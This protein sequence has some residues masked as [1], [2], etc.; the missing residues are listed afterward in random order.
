MLHSFCIH[1]HFY[2]PDREDPFSNDIPLDTYVHQLSRRKYSNWNELINSQCYAPNA[3]LG[4]F[5]LI[6]FDV[7]R[8][9]AEWLKTHDTVT[10]HEIL[11]S[12][13]MVY[14]RDKVS[15]VFASSWDHVILPLM[16]DVDLKIQI[17]WGIRDFKRRFG[18]ESSSFWLPETAVSYRVL[19][20][21]A[22]QGIR[23]IILSSHQSQQSIDPSK[24][25]KVRLDNNL[26]IDVAFFNK[27]LSDKLSFDN[28]GMADADSFV[29][30]I[31][32]ADSTKNNLSFML[33]AT[34]GERYGHHMDGGQ[35]F[36]NRLLSKSIQQR[37]YE[38]LP[39]TTIH[40]KS[41]VTDE[42]K[43]ADLSSWSCLCGGLKRW[44][45]DCNCSLDYNNHNARVDGTWKSHL[46]G[47]I[48]ALSNDLWNYSH[49]FF[50]KVL[51]NPV[52]ACCD[53][54]DVIQ[55]E[56]TESDFL[57]KHGMAPLESNDIHKLFVL[58]SM[59]RYRLASFTSCSTFF[60]QLD[61]PEPRIVIHQAKKALSFLSL[62][63]EHALMYRLEASFIDTLSKAVDY[64][65]GLTGKDLYEETGHL[66]GEQ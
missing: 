51:R 30:G 23:L 52:D 57:A 55:H 63:H 35:Q 40:L 12:A 25:Y 46:F 56:M 54:A 29:K 50:T 27:E 49:T 39:I 64:K 31:P 7:V 37:G 11:K 18:F 34:D 22:K 1:G 15:H 32:V 66:Y 21:L 2:Q 36:L 13:Q 4:N 14:A 33:G 6:S 44:M 8:P 61:R 48:S 19:N 62:I 16:N 10:Y 3:K 26:S 5:N 45:N 58:L 20:E 42:A 41:N 59:Q 47:A 60:W 53:Y 43:I 65:S 38:V 24:F 17:V 9:L 28:S